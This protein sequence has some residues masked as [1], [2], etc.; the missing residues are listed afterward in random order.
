[1]VTTTISATEKRNNCWLPWYPH[2]LSNRMGDLVLG[3]LGVTSVVLGDVSPLGSPMRLHGIVVSMHV[4]R[5]T[6]SI[7]GMHEQTDRFEM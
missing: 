5:W 3:K 1:M 2:T 6:K 4:K 7:F